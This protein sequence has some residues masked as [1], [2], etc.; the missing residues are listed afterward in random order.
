MNGIAHCRGG[1][2]P[3]QAPR[4]GQLSLL[5]SIAERGMQ[6]PIGSD[7]NMGGLPGRAWMRRTR[8]PNSAATSRPPPE[9]AARHCRPWR[10]PLYLAH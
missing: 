10:L 2:W 3:D 6:S 4:P 1:G 8:V 7:T 5:C 9:A